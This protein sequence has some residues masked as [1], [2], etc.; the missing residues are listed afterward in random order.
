MTSQ[1]ENVYSTEMSQKQ[2]IYNHGNYDYIVAYPQNYGQPI[3]VTT[4]I[5]PLQTIIPNDVFNWYYSYMYGQLYLPPVANNYIWT[6]DDIIM[7]FINQIQ[8]G[9]NAQMDIVNIRELQKYLKLIIPAEMSQEELDTLDLPLR[10]TVAIFPYQSRTT[11]NF[12]PF[13]ITAGIY[14]SNSLANVTPALRYST[15]AAPNPDSKP[16]IGPAHFSAGPLGVGRIITFKIPFRLI[17]NSYFALNKNTYIGDTSLLTTYMGS[18]NNVC[19]QSTSNLDPNQGTI[20]AYV[21]DN[22][23][24]A[25][26]LNFQLFLAKETNL[27]NREMAI[28]ELNSG[29]PRYIPWVQTFKNPNQGS[30]QNQAL[31]L[32]IGF[33][34]ALQKMYYSIFN[35]VESLNTCYDNTNSFYGPLNTTPANQKVKFYQTSIGSTPEEIRVLY[36]T[37]NSGNGGFDDYLRN[38]KMLKGSLLQNLDEYQYNWFHCSN[39]IDLPAENVQNNDQKLLSGL[40][41][42]G[43]Y[44]AW[45]F[46]GTSMA[47]A[48]NNFWHYGF[49]IFT[50]ILKIDPTQMVVV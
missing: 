2:Y 33:G 44:T 42:S 4:S 14:R 49:G 15:T 50:R 10:G 9:R 40:P 18:I 20:A 26:I 28:A 46:N 3:P 6:F 27:K 16:Y 8:Y 5:S 32:N 41:M 37:D 17:K 34:H 36:C 43:E 7:P 31:N 47:A 12:E 45:T 23:L 13:G 11:D 48:S 25:S 29:I 35:N 30:T 39:Y 22:T 1:L 19:Y 38:K 24:T 21:P